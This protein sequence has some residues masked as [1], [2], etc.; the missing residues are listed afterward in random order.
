MQISRTGEMSQ[1]PHD[2]VAS[3]LYLEVQRFLYREAALLDTRDYHGWLALTG[4]NVRYQVN[5]LVSRDAGADPITTSIIDEDRIGLK[6]RIEQISNPKLTRA[7]NPPSITR[8]VVTNIEAYHCGTLGNFLAHSYL[9]AY[10]SRPSIPEGGFYVARRHDVLQRNHS[11]WLL[12]ERVVQLDQFMLFG[13]ALS[14]L[15]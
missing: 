9:L 13:G 1:A 10:R 12:L 14:T 11:G 3:E 7:E 15:L 4:D 8:R 6:S 5:V 2:P